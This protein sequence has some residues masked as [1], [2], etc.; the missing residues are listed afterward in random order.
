MEYIGWR[1]SKSF[2]IVILDEEQ[3]NELK[4]VKDGS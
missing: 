3:L 4:G 2:Y 1:A